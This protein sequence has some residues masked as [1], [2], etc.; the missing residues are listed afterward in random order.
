MLKCL[1]CKKTCLY[2][3]QPQSQ[4]NF[5][6]LDFFLLL[7]RMF[8]V[9]IFFFLPYNIRRK[10]I[11][12]YSRCILPFPQCEVKRQF[13][14]LLLKM[15]KSFTCLKN[16][17]S[18]FTQRIPWSISDSIF[19]LMVLANVSANLRSHNLNPLYLLWKSEFRPLNLHK[20][21]KKR[22][23]P[24]NQII[25]KTQESLLKFRKQELLFSCL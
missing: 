12:K 13:I 22:S 16:T 23:F 6:V 1:I 8:W 21:S 7:L 10:T 3:N 5:L 9:Y 19:P 4:D 18:V 2:K 14:F 15:L 20:A 17:V 25:F 24:W 11:C